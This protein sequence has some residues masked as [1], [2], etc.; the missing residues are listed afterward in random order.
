MEHN[1][2][3]KE[4]YWLIIN[5]AYALKQKINTQSL[6][7]TIPDQ[8]LASLWTTRDGEYL[9]KQEYMSTEK[10]VLDKNI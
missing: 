10:R 3:I 2:F 9:L 8:A 6:K 4:Q 1:P 5:H 7:H